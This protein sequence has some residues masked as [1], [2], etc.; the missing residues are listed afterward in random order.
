MRTRGDGQ[1]VGGEAE[2]LAW[3]GGNA[4][5]RQAGRWSGNR[6]DGGE[7]SRRTGGRAGTLKRGQTG[8][9][10][11]GYAGERAGRRTGEEAG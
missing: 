6:Y 7:A 8:R 4:G 2:T 3:A 1:A 10:R 9:R 5:R 11:G